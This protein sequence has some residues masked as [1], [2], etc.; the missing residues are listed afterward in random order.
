MTVVMVQLHPS[1]RHRGWQDG[2]G[3]VHSTHVSAVQLLRSRLDSGRVLPS[4]TCKCYQRHLHTDVSLS[5]S[6]H[7]AAS[8]AHMGGARSSSRVVPPDEGCALTIKI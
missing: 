5:R 4:N 6:K 3:R 7:K 1:F 2:C 8:I